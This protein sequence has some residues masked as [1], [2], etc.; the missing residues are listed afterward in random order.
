MKNTEVKEYERPN[1]T[2]KKVTDKTK[3][4][5]MKEICDEIMNFEEE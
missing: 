4:L 1:N 5:H 2:L 3:E